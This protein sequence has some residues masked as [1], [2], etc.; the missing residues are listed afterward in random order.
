MSQPWWKQSTVVDEKKHDGRDVSMP[1][2]LQFDLATLR[3]V[4]L[5]ALRTTKNELTPSFLRKHSSGNP[6]K[7]T[8]LR[9]TSYLDGIRAVAT[10]V[11]V[12]SHTIVPHWGLTQTAY[13]RDGGNH[14]VLLL[15]FIR[16]IFAGRSMVYILYVV[17]GYV[18]SY[19]IFMLQRDNPWE[20]APISLTT[21]VFRR[22]LRLYLPTLF[23]SFVYMLGTYFGLLEY[24]RAFAADPAMLL[25]G[26]GALPERLDTLGAQ[27]WDWKQ[28]MWSRMTD[29]FTWN[30]LV[31]PKYDSHL[32]TIR[33]QF[34]ASMVVY[35]VILLLSR[36]KSRFRLPVLSVVILFCFF[37]GRWECVIH[38]A[39]TVLAELD[40]RHANTAPM[41]PD[42]DGN[43][44]TSPNLKTKM[45]WIFNLISALYLLSTPM[46]EAFNT[47]GFIWLDTHIPSFLKEERYG[48]WAML[49]AM[50]FIW[51]MTR[52]KSFQHIFTNA[53]LLY[54]GKISYMMYILHGPVM[55]TAGYAACMHMFRVFGNDNMFGWANGIFTE[56]VVVFVVV[57]CLSDIVFRLV[58]LECASFGRWLELKLFMPPTL[59]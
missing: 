46:N 38:L 40:T 27:I 59:S 49:G 50:Q 45:F 10:I 14:H 57:I 36:V 11:V 52:C 22:W 6:A 51:V 32:W 48:I 12:F 2:Q 29:N 25:G 54:L 23:V 7:V 53:P 3:L 13:G 44:S 30:T 16:L 31:L 1:D 5:K 20:K 39:G 19:N 15:P 18:L 41:L 8:R 17:S 34:N 21:S 47:P 37:W 4:S 24:T 9:P 28:G 35:A 26:P 33:S 42:H 56:L 58:E 55:R 43:R